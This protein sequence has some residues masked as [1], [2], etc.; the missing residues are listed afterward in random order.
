LSTRPLFSALLGE[1]S[2]SGGA[3][4]IGPVPLGVI[5]VVRDMRA[6]FYG[7]PWQCVGNLDVSDNAGVT[8]WHLEGDEGRGDH[9]YT[10]EGRQV[11]DVG[12]QLNCFFGSFGGSLRVTGYVL[13]AP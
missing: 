11:L 1:V 9:T 7:R 10:W 5:W 4:T 6:M 2:S 13:T 8:V 12:D 3:F